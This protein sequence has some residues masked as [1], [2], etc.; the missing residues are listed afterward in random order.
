MGG[1]GEHTEGPDRILFEENRIGGSTDFERRRTSGGDES[2]SRHRLHH[3]EA[4]ESVIAEPYRLGGDVGRGTHQVGA[5]KDLDPRL[6]CQRQ[7][8]SHTIE[9]LDEK[10]SAAGLR[11]E[12]GKGR[13][14]TEHGGHPHAAAA[15]QRIEVG[16]FEKHPVLD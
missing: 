13:F 7:E 4:G 2:G 9:T 6:R 8:S 14:A 12:L 3:L 5:G 15:R 10:R 11:A 1:M 16:L